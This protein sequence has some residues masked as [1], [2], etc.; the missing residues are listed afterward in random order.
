MDPQLLAARCP[1]AE[2]LVDAEGRVEFGVPGLEPCASVERTTPE[3]WPYCVICR[4]G[5]RQVRGEKSTREESLSEMVT[6]LRTFECPGDLSD[7]A[8]PKAI[9][10]RGPVAVPS[11]PIGFWHRLMTRIAAAFAPLRRR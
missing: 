8:D 4:S 9:M 10:L 3:S 6:W 7:Y 5:K 1:E 11:A 2:Q